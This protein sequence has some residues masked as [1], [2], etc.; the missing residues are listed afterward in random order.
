MKTAVEPL[1]L[2]TTG[3]LGQRYGVHRDTVWDWI[4]TGIE[5]AGGQRVRLKAWRVGGQYKTTVEEA[6]KFF[7]AC[8][9]EEGGQTV[10]EPAGAAA[11]RAQAEQE[12]ARRELGRKRK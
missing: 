9:G 2:L 10:A 7:A 12:K 3:Q 6:E 11:R 4:R 5:G 8:A 1:P